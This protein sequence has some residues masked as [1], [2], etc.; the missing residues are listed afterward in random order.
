VAA[1]WVL[2]LALLSTAS[3]ADEFEPPPRR[4]D[5]PILDE[6][7]APYAARTLSVALQ[8]DRDGAR[9]VAY[10]VKDRPFDLTRTQPPARPYVEGHPLLLEV[11]LSSAQG[12]GGELFTRR[13]SV[14]PLC[15]SHGPGAPPHVQGDTILLHRDSFVVELP[16]LP[17][18]DHV[19]VTFF[20][21][22]RGRTTRRPVGVDT[23]DRARF[24]PAGSAHRYEQ[25]AFADPG[26][27]A[28]AGHTESSTA[29]WPEDFDDPEIFRVWGSA[30]EV[31]GRINVVI[32]PDGY[33]YSEK[34]IMEAHAQ[35]M[36]THFRSKTPYAEHDP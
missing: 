10:T 19:S 15:F 27:P 34:A 3:F 5:R 9:I 29:I 23:L 17:N 4:V 36:V 21:K 16:E 35:A 2:A 8:V 32:V 18:L 30:G 7:V 22:S 33:T 12:V 20:E 6:P 26:A 1:V 28:A 24:A 11:V 13:Q 31:A 25:L 14:G